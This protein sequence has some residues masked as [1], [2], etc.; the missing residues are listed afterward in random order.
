MLHQLASV[1]VQGL[2]VNAE[3]FL[4]SFPDPLEKTI[5]LTDQP[6]S[7]G[8]MV[9]SNTT[10]RVTGDLSKRRLHRHSVPLTLYWP[11]FPSHTDRHDEG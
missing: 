8:E 1:S 4:S 6:K 11:D 2:S 9:F 7:I 3:E 10:F 5:S